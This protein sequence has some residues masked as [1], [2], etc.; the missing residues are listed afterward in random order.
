M[1]IPDAVRTR[2]VERVARKTHDIASALLL[3]G[4]PVTARQVRTWMRE[5]Y[6]TGTTVA[7]RRRPNRQ[8]AV[9]EED[10]VV[11]MDW[12]HQNSRRTY[13]D[14]QEY[15][16]AETGHAYST[17]TIFNSFRKRHISRKKIVVV[18]MQRDEQYRRKFRIRMRRLVVVRQK[19]WICA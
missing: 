11:L 12:L 3:E 7:T 18:A 19:P 1:T 14:M 5:H 13:R 16:Y 6:A 9:T 10:F 8:S 17:K 15:V 4:N 2:I